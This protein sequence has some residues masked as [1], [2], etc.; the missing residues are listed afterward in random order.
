MN[1]VAIMLSVFLFGIG[2]PDG[3]PTKPA[4]HTTKS[5]AA[6]SQKILPLL[7][8]NIPKTNLFTK[9]IFQVLI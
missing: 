5:H 4:Q 9:S 2:V 6:A 3:V 8:E 1:D 7:G